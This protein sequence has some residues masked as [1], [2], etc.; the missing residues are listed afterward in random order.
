MDWKSESYI[1]LFSRPLSW[2]LCTII[3]LYS[4]FSSVSFPSLCLFD[5]KFCFP[6]VFSFSLPSIHPFPSLHLSRFL[7]FLTVRQL[8]FM[9]IYFRVFNFVFCSSSF[10]S[11]S[12]SPLYL[13]PAPSLSPPPNQYLSLLCFSFSSFSS[14][15]LTHFLFFFFLFPLNRIPSLLFLFPFSFLLSIYAHQ[16]FHYLSHLSSHYYLFSPSRLFPFD[17]APEVLLV[18]RW[19]Q[20]AGVGQLAFLCSFLALSRYLS[21]TYDL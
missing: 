7:R 11:L 2:T 6:S 5:L 3:L 20:L 13:N 17:E 12:I 19:E 21:G 8:H 16:P 18:S 4:F 15:C 9:C 14:F 10:S 1:E